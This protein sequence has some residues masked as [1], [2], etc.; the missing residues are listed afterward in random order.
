MAR[1]KDTRGKIPDLILKINIFIFFCAHDDQLMCLASGKCEDAA[2]F[3]F[4]ID[5][6]IYLGNI[7]LNLYTY[8]IYIFFYVYLYSQI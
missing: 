7:N 4:F 6:S 2:G 3:L 8:V 1:H 5:L